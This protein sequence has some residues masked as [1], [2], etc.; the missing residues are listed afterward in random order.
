MSFASFLKRLGGTIRRPG[1]PFRWV[2]I[3]AGAVA[4]ILA[5]GLSTLVRWRL[6]G[7][8]EG[9]FVLR[10]TDR[11]WIVTDDLFVGDEH[12]VLFKLTSPR[13]SH[14]V[15]T[16]HL[17]DTFSPHLS[18]EWNGRG[19]R[20]YVMQS[21]P[22][23]TRLLTCFSRFRDDRGDVPSGL[24]VGG[25]LPERLGEAP[26]VT[27]TETGMA[28]NDGEEWHHL[29][30]SV[31]EFFAPA[32]GPEET[33]SPSRWKYLGSRVLAG[34]GHQLVITSAH[35]VT[36]RGA[37]LLVDKYAFFRAE[38]SWFVLATRVRNLGPGRAVYYYSY[39]D[40]PWVGNF[41]TSR[42]NVGWMKGRMVPYEGAID[43][44]AT[45]F[46]GMCDVGNR[47]IG[48]GTN[49]SRMANFL[50]WFGEPK[51]D[52]VYFSNKIGPLRKPEELIP[53]FTDTSRSLFLQWGPRVLPPN[54][55]ETYLMAVGM[56]G[57]AA[58]VN[59]LPVKPPVT[60]DRRILDYLR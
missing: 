55:S 26:Q 57:R 18:W 60:V 19:G 24:F 44:D 34:D 50:Q 58:S 27:M 13:L 29:W 52:L 32:Y 16:Y 30:C 12:R 3:L 14:M 31:N 21:Y 51:P 53:L 2:A 42:G 41:G 17:G 36:F 8:Y 49:Y 7:D 9:F 48:E 4:V 22:G 23:G 59:D 5:V 47:V 37:N 1:R 35:Q 56:A 39:G 54:G 38:D 10:G 45:D 28:F 11:R 40:D 46:I 33:I 15:E 20:G 25:G 43:H 6:T